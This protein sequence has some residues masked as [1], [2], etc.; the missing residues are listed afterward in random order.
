MEVSL[1]KVQPGS[2]ILIAHPHEMTQ[3]VFGL[4]YLP[5]LSIIERSSLV[6]IEHSHPAQQILTVNPAIRD[7]VGGYNDDPPDITD[8]L[9][10]RLPASAPPHTRLYWRRWQARYDYLYLI[11]VSDQPNPAPDRLIELYRGDNFRLYQIEPPDNR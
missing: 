8:I 9:A 4:F 3:A 10:E 6:S 7:F 2:R 11:W 5:C 1:L